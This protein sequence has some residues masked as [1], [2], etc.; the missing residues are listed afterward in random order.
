MDV[1]M[2]N[3][4]NSIPLFQGLNGIDLNQLFYKVE[5]E[6]ELLRPKEK[7]CS[8]GNLCKQMTILL[9]GTLNAET[10]S[11]DGIYSVTEQVESVAL[12]EADI[13]YGMQREWSSTYTA[14]NECRLM[15]IPK[16]AVNKMMDKLEVFRLNYLNAVCTLAAKRRQ[17]E[18]KAPAPTLRERLVQF[19][20]S[21]TLRTK[22][23][24]QIKIMTKDLCPYM[25]FS[26]P[27]I[28][29]VLR[30][31]QEEGLMKYTHG[32]MKIPNIENLQ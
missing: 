9:G 23:P 28:T 21:H 14:K 2:Y 3:T 20:L 13:L 31:M 30:Q 19:I 22:G 1:R 12:L 18:W 32:I 25:G 5:F 10:I 6:I 8:Q 11:P 24:L 4:L 16:N 7:L 27:I 15:L 17:K 26:R 29:N